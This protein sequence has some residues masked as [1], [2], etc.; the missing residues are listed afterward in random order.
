MSSSADTVD[1]IIHTAVMEV[2]LNAAIFAATAQLPWLLG[3][4]IL[5][6]L[7]R[8][9]VTFA[10]GFLDK[11]LEQAA[12]FAI[13]DSQTQAEALAYQE[14]VSELKKAQLSGDPHALAKATQDF[15]DTFSRL[16]HW[17]GA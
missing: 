13:I 10:F 12:A 9:A 16:I 4:P 14:K 2:A 1:A 8:W 3:L 11:Y 17:D 5:R 15:K 7:F 6:N